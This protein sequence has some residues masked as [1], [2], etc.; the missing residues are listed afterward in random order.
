MPKSKLEM[1]VDILKIIAQNYSFETSKIADSLEMG[2]KELKL[3]LTFLAKQGLV[4]KQR[5][6]NYGVVYLIT[7]EGIKV[8]RYFNELKKVLPVIG[9]I[10][11]S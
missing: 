9:K 1:Y 5:V 7:L 2:N 8:L 3:R 10:R 6:Y 11:E 4:D